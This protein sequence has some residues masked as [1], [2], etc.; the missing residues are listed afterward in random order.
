MDITQGI[1]TTKQKSLL[2]PELVDNVFQQEWLC[3]IEWEKKMFPDKD[4]EG[5]GRALF[6]NTMLTGA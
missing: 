4:L 3:N 6:Q 5:R 2:T 1:F